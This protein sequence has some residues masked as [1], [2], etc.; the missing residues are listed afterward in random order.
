MLQNVITF[1]KTALVMILGKGKVLLLRVAF[2]VL[3]IK[4]VR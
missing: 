4:L 1:F 2:F 3:L